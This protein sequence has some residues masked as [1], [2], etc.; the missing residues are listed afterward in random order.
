MAFPLIPILAGL[1]IIGGGAYPALVRQPEHRAEGRADR[2]AAGYAQ[3]LFN[4]TVD[5]LSAAETRD[6]HDRVKAYFNN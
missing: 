6:V 5:Q 1:G 3:S 4:K 2:L